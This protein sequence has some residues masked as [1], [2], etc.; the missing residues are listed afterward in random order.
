[1]PRAGLSRAE[2]IRAGAALADEAGYANLAMAP[3]AERLGVR[4]PSLYKHVEGIAD[5]QQEIAALAMTEL[6]D[7]VRDALQGRS[8]RDALDAFARAFCSYIADHPGRYTATLGRPTHGPEEDPL[9]KAGTR[10]LEST[11]AVLRDYDLPPED[12]T[13]A[14]RMLRSAFHGFATL[15]GADGFQWPEQT[16]TALTWMIDFL[17]RGLRAR[18]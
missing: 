10:L 18:S 15:S 11:G 9:V 3:L 12:T 14:L 13:H 1:M 17:D 6:A 8:G 2:V 5:L 4:T 16:A 7:R